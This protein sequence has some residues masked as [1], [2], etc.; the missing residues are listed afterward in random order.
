MSGALD[1]DESLPSH[2]IFVR[3]VCAEGDDGISRSDIVASVLRASQESTRSIDSSSGTKASMS[4]PTRATSKGESTSTRQGEMS[5]PPPPP[6]SFDEMP[7][8]GANSSLLHAPQS[9]LNFTTPNGV[10]SNSNGSRM[11]GN[12]TN[13]GGSTGSG[14]K[15]AFLKRGR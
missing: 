10:S 4:T 7:L 11:T 3:H 14:K 15:H 2:S 1:Y 12:S 9:T 8:R 13:S 5:P 6:L